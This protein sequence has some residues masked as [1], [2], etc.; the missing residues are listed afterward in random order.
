MSSARTD[1]VFARVVS[2]HQTC[3]DAPTLQIVS[4]RADTNNLRPNARQ[5]SVSHRLC[6]FLY[7]PEKKKAQWEQL[8]L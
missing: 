7:G 4:W 2:L 3:P 1:F 8:A 6:S 5:T